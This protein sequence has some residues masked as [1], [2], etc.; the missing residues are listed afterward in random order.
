[1]KTFEQFNEVDPF[2]EDNWDE[3]C[4]T[5]FTYYDIVEKLGWEILEFDENE[6]TFKTSSPLRHN[7][8]SISKEDN[9]FWLT[10][11]EDNLFK[12]INETIIESPTEISLRK[13]FWE[14]IHI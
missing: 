7:N 1:M 5:L 13:A 9:N 11:Y 3:E 4:I 12:L 8:F 10:R 6:F 2:G 14:L